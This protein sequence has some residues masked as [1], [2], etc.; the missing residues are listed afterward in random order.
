MVR[1]IDLS[2]NTFE[3]SLILMHEKLDELGWSYYNGDIHIV[4]PEAQTSRP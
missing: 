3:P 1:Q 4:E 2:W